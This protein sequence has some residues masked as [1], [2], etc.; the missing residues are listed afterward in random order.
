[1]QPPSPAS[2]QHLSKA[3]YGIVL[4]SFL[5]LVVCMGLRGPKPVD[6]NDLESWYGAWLRIFDG[7]CTGRYIRKDLDYE[8]EEALW[9]RLLN[10]TTPEQVR[11]VCDESPYWL[12][13]KRGSIL[14]YNVLARN[15]QSFLAAK[16]DRRWPKSVRP[17]NQGR[18]IRF[19]ARSM[20]GITMGISI[21]TAQD[22][23]AKTE[24]QKLAAVYRPICVC[25]H[26]ERDHKDRGRCKYCICSN[27]QY[28]GGK[29][30]EW[31][32]DSQ[33]TKA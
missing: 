26:R 10:A 8:D 3:I 32:A 21:R 28:S 25:G 4:Y 24:K 12:N 7:M 23:L 11:A 6:Q 31:P 20:A 15:A 1:V 9:L 17:T 33:Q 13:P 5:P 18:Q 19:L 16:E 30:M 29:E 27:Y 14:F 2:H 22:L